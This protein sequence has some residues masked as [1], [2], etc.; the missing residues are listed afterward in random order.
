M[1]AACTAIELLVLTHASAGVQVDS[2]E[3]QKGLQSALDII[4]NA[5]NDDESDEPEEQ[6]DENQNSQQ[7]NQT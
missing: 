5:E 6:Y 1:D 2:A 7:N 3:Y 4:H